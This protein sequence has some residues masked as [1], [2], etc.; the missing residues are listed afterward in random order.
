MAFC[1]VFEVQEAVVRTRLERPAPL[2]GLLVLLAL[3]LIV[4]QGIGASSVQQVGI[5]VVQALQQMDGDLKT[6]FCSYKINCFCVGLTFTLLLT[7]DN[8]KTKTSPCFYF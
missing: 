1:C 6:R 3:R 2:P 8:A 5:K 7:L 4:A